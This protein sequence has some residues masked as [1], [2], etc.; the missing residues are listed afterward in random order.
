M[1]TPPWRG[2]PFGTV[3]GNL[4]FSYIILF[5]EMATMDSWINPK[6][7]IRASSI[8]GNGMFAVEPIREGETVLVWGGEYTDKANA[9][10]ARAEGKL[11]LQWD[12]NLYSVEERGADRGYFI[13]HSCDSNTWMNGVRTLIAKRDIAVGEEVTADYALWEV[14]ETYVSKWECRCGTAVCRKRVTGNDWRLTEVQQRYWNHFSPLINKMIGI[15]R[16]TAESI[17]SRTQ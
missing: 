16:G 12:D 17:E 5:K 10:R 15:D 2:V 8:D 13:N 3:G 1:P 4:R 9:L 11:I 7:E 14:K 6:V